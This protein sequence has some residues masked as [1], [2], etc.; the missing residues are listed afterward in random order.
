MLYKR[1]PLLYVDIKSLMAR[2]PKLRSHKQQG[3]RPEEKRFVKGTKERN[4]IASWV[5]RRMDLLPPK[6]CS[7]SV[8]DLAKMFVDR[9][10]QF[11]KPGGDLTS[12]V[13]RTLNSLFAHE[14]LD[15]RM[16]SG[17][18][19]RH[20]IEIEELINRCVMRP[21]EIQDKDLRTRY[22]NLRSQ[23]EIWIQFGSCGERFFPQEKTKKGIPPTPR[24][25]ANE[26]KRFLKDLQKIQQA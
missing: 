14:L 3:S 23:T 1:S 19:N 18:Q 16:E 10:P 25:F 26:L 2:K 21:S 12:K 11:R 7:V 22:R 8:Q 9:Y 5:R 4:L 15:L 24:S 20:S 17:A 6:N 13:K